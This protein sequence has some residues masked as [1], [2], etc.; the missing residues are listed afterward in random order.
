MRVQGSCAEPSAKTLHL[1]CDDGA[2]HARDRVPGEKAARSLIAAWLIQLCRE[3]YKA[4]TLASD[5][6]EPSK[7]NGSRYAGS[8]AP[9]QGDPGSGLNVVGSSIGSA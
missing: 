1:L 7:L 3:A 4:P 9:M 5:L 8:A 2:N 6:A